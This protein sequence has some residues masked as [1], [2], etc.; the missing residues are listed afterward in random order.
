[1]AASGLSVQWPSKV[2]AASRALGLEHSAAPLEALRA[3]VAMVPHAHGSEFPS[4]TLYACVLECVRA[5]GKGQPAALAGPRPDAGLGGEQLVAVSGHAREA[6]RSKTPA[7][8]AALFPSP[9]LPS[10]PLPHSRMPGLET[11]MHS[12]GRGRR[13]SHGRGI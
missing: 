12:R 9:P 11:R 4:S 3:A 6:R 13:V 5:R 8:V 7:H 1:M 10:P 2:Q